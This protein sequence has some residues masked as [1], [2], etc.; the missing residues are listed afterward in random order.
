MEGYEYDGPVAE[1]K[2]DK[3]L[4]AGEQQLGL[5][6]QFYEYAPAAIWPIVQR[7]EFLEGQATERYPEPARLQS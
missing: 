6:T 7:S 5:N 1:C 4:Q 2:G 3:T